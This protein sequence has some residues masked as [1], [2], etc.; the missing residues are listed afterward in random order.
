MRRILALLFCVLSTAA[1]A[2]TKTPIY[3]MAPLHSLITASPPRNLVSTPNFQTCGFYNCGDLGDNV[4]TYSATPCSPVDNATCMQDQFGNYFTGSNYTDGVGFA[5]SLKFGCVPDAVNG[6]TTA[7]G[8]TPTDNSACGANANA[9]AIVNHLAGVSWC[10]NSVGSGW[11]FATS[12]T[13]TTTWTCQGR[14][15][16]RPEGT[17][18]PS[19]SNTADYRNYPYTLW[20]PSTA[21]INVGKVETNLGTTSAKLEN[22]NVIRAGYNTTGLAPTGN[23]DLAAIIAAYAGTGVLVPADSSQ[24]SHVRILGFNIG[25]DLNPP[26][27]VVIDDVKIDSTNC[28]LI[29][30][31]RGGGDDKVK[32]ITCGSFGTDINPHTLVNLPEASITDSFAVNGQHNILYTLTAS[33]TGQDCPSVGGFAWATNPPGAESSY[34]H[35]LTLTQGND[36]TQWIDTGSTSDFLPSQG[37]HVFTGVTIEAGN[38]VIL[39]A[40]VPLDCNTSETA[41]HGKP[42]CQL[43]P[44]QQITD[45][46]GC[47]TYAGAPSYY[48]FAINFWDGSILLGDNNFHRIIPKG[49]NGADTG[50]CTNDTITI[51]D[52]T[53]GFKISTIAVANG[54]TG[55]TSDDE[56]VICTFTGGTVTGTPGSFQIDTVLGGAVTKVETIDIGL[57]SVFPSSPFPFT[58]N[59]TLNV[60]GL[61]VTITDQGAFS[62]FAAQR[63]GYGMKFETKNSALASVSVLNPEVINYAQGIVYGNH[64]SYVDVDQAQINCQNTQQDNALIGVWFTKL[65]QGNVHRGGQIHCFGGEIIDNSSDPFHSVPSTVSGVNTGGN[66]LGGDNSIIF[67]KA[68]ATQGVPSKTALNLENI[69]PSPQTSF[70]F[71]SDNTDGISL[72]GVRGLVT[73]VI[74]QTEGSSSLI[75]RASSVFGSQ[76]NVAASLSSN[77]MT[78]S[79]GVVNGFLTPTVSPYY[80]FNAACGLVLNAG[81]SGGTLSVILSSNPVIGFRMWFVPSTS[82]GFSIDPNGKT[83]ID[84]NTVSRTTPLIIAPST[85]TGDNIFSMAWTGAFWRIDSG[86]PGTISQNLL[87]QLV[88][89]DNGQVYFSAD[90]V[91]QVVQ[92]LPSNGLGWLII[93]GQS[94]QIPPTGIYSP[95]TAATGVSRINMYYAAKATFTVSGVVNVGGVVNVQASTVLGLQNGD[96]F[97]LWNVGGVAEANTSG[98]VAN[99]G[100]HCA[101][102][103]DLA[104]VSFVSGPYTS[105]GNGTYLYLFPQAASGAGLHTN[106]NGVEVEVGNTARSYVGLAYLDASQHFNDSAT[107]RDVASLYNARTK[108]CFITLTG[109]KTTSSTGLAELDTSARC[110]FVTTGPTVNGA[111]VPNAATWDMGGSASNNTSGDGIN[112]AINFDGTTTMTR[113]AGSPTAAANGQVLGFGFGGAWSSLTE[114]AH[115]CR[116][117]GAVVTGGTATFG[118]NTSCEVRVPQ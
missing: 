41:W 25:L 97:N 113:D 34:G 14:D 13:L 28:F 59:Q 8:G 1:G 19:L 12:P 7:L 112:A 69:A 95:A 16:G 47:L 115:D 61:T 4:F 63:S 29:A 79:C 108:N 84:G 74:G 15:P 6:N 70:G 23:K 103:F 62:L 107:Q 54:G 82:F 73:H 33:C 111:V 30:G 106:L 91:N 102:C 48:D 56:G 80:A 36:T 98:V 2:Q 49:P 21:T 3:G 104:A 46:E 99:V 116:P 92:V 65:E 45:S 55:G 81:G 52:H 37:G 10:G 26:R 18:S 27:D 75:K 101:T 110:H 85:S 87:A 76:S 66:S 39:L 44:G 57:Y 117:Y 31:Q 89:G 32:T 35:R 100:V 86:A 9:A 58:C 38:S 67:A 68:P 60:T 88:P 24:I 71:V 50:T 42:F 64:A 40:G 109:T 5:K 90:T 53:L 22:L 17:G 20:I 93:N 51:V 105:G 118:A 78:A 77:P 43:N 72:T 83:I 11:F 96:P 114:G 94:V